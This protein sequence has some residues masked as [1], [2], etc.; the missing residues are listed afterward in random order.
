MQRQPHTR[1]L[2]RRLTLG[3]AAAAAL[4]AASAAQAEFRL[5]VAASAHSSA[6][7]ERSFDDTV[8]RAT[9]YMFADQSNANGSIHEGGPD[10][11]PPIVCGQAATPGATAAATVDMNTGHMGVAARAWTNPP[12]PHAAQ[13]FSVVDVS[14]RLFAS[15]NLTFHIRVDFGLDASQGDDTFA[16]YQFSLTMRDTADAIHTLFGLSAWDDPKGDSPWGVSG[17]GASTFVERFWEGPGQGSHQEFTTVPSVFSISID[18]PASVFDGGIDLG[19]RNY[20]KAESEDSNNAS[21]SS[22][23]SGYLGITGNYA[24]SAGYNY[25]G[26]AAVVPEPGTAAL[27]LAGAGLLL[28]ARHRR[29]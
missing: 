25:V 18:V 21:V 6:S 19:I 22:L 4:L 8:K 3:I 20:A 16:L 9:G 24:S 28:R 27:W 13:S 11:C 1:P 26:Y 15:G 29:G 7:D 14:D 23:N 5:S 2:N 17:R 10:V 12:K